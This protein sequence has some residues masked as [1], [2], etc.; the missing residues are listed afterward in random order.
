MKLSFLLPS[1]FAILFCLSSDVSVHAK[2]LNGDTQLQLLVGLETRLDHSEMNRIF[3]T[4]N[5][6]RHLKADKMA[7]AAKAKAHFSMCLQLYR[8]SLDDHNQNSNTGPSEVKGIELIPLAK[9]GSRFY[10]AGSAKDFALYLNKSGTNEGFFIS[11]E[12]K[13]NGKN[14]VT[15]MAK[16]EDGRSAKKFSEELTECTGFIGAFRRRASPKRSTGSTSRVLEPELPQNQDSSSICPFFPPTL[17]YLEYTR[18]NKVTQQTVPVNDWYDPIEPASPETIRAMYGVPTIDNTCERPQY[19]PRVAAV[20][21]YGQV[22]G[23]DDL[24]CYTKLN[25]L[26]DTTVTSVDVGAGDFGMNASNGLCTLPGCLCPTQGVTNCYEGNLDVQMIAAMSGVTDITAFSYSYNSNSTVTELESTIESYEDVIH[27][28]MNL[29]EDNNAPSVL[30]ISYGTCYSASDEDLIDQVVEICKRI[31]LVTM[32]KGTTVFVSSGD[33]GATGER[34][35]YAQ[36]GICGI[37]C[38]AALAGCP[39]VTTVGGSFGSKAGTEE[40]STGMPAAEGSPQ[41]QGLNI[42]SGGGFSKIFTT[43][44]GFDLSFQEASVNNWRQQPTDNSFPGYT[45]PDGSVGRGFPDVSAKSDNILELNGGQWLNQD[46][47]SASTPMFAGM[48]NLCAS[49]LPEDVTG[50]GWINPSLYN[51]GGIFYDII[52]GNNY[53]PCV[54]QVSSSSICLAPERLLKAHLLYTGSLGDTVFVVIKNTHSTFVRQAMSKNGPSIAF[55]FDI[56]SRGYDFVTEN[57]KEVSI[58]IYDSDPDDGDSKVLLN[59]VTLS[60]SC[61]GPWTILNSITPNSGLLLIGRTVFVVAD[62]KVYTNTDVI[63]EGGFFGFEATE[64]WDPASGLGTLGTTDGGSFNSLCNVLLGAPFD[65][66]KL[67]CGKPAPIPIPTTAP[68]Q[69][70]TKAKN[71]KKNQS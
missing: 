17:S 46:G 12:E 25:N 55:G 68:T 23:T 11:F 37:Y 61:P 2:T 53:Y 9:D 14:Q 32:E 27:Q 19:F 16:Y 34:K 70:N 4:P 38:Q 71:S 66:N 47:T 29:E 35:G 26:Q 10:L 1:A 48:V 43:E 22:I 64:G 50:F 52:R 20:F 39:Y 5:H 54:P 45:L 36:N 18:N 65:L 24:A 41:P 58:T 15:I 56:S 3:S 28:I 57:F 49:Q 8:S 59:N 67:E 69:K 44:K 33:Y 21:E 63:S 7:L 42:V 51:N 40:L 6:H 31:G 62:N 30:S 60:T 13:L